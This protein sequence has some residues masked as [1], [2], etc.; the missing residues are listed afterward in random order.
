M[1]PLP[2]AVAA[3][4]EFFPAIVLYRTEFVTISDNNKI[5]ILQKNLE[6]ILPLATG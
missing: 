4:R 2:N 3:I 5:G 1:P 6:V